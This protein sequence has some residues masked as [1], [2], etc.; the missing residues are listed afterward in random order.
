MNRKTHSV[1][2]ASPMPGGLRRSSG[3]ASPKL[4]GR[5]A[6]AARHH[7]QGARA[8]ST[9]WLSG[10]AR[11]RSAFSLMPGRLRRPS[12]LAPIGAEPAPP[13]RAS[14][15]AKEPEPIQR[16]G[17]RDKRARCDLPW[18]GHAA[19][20]AF[21]LECICRFELFFAAFFMFSDG[22]RELAQRISAGLLR[23]QGHFRRRAHCS[24]LAHWG[25]KGSEDCE[26]WLRRQLLR[27]PRVI[28]S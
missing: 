26:A 24:A 8:D 10:R 20:V 13:P 17:S 1:L 27:G 2:L 25:N 28:K 19:S 12:G 9:A 18:V 7:R 4:R 5:A 16:P 23:W 15:I 3:L 21:W 14:P 11:A 22:S 6:A